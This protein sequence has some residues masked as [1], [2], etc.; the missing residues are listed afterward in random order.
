MIELVVFEGRSKKTFNT[1]V[2]IGRGQWRGRVRGLWLANRGVHLGL[3]PTLLG[4]GPVDDA[5]WSL[6]MVD[7]GRME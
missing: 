6:R 4:L 5:K 2:Y 3:P 1:N 7:L